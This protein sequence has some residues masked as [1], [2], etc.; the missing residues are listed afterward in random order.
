MKITIGTMEANPENPSSYAASK[1]IQD[2]EFDTDWF[3]NTIPSIKD[4]HVFVPEWE[5]ATDPDTVFLFFLAEYAK[6]L[7]LNNDH[8][9]CEEA[10]KALKLYNEDIN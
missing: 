7:P 1:R 4:T 8:L 2:I 9:L 6:D 5:D 10:K 3:I